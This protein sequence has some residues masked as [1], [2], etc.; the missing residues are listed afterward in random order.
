MA[1]LTGCES[2]AILGTCSLAI[3]A[4]HIG[5]DTQSL[6]DTVGNFVKLQLYTY[7]EVGSATLTSLCTPSARSSAETAGSAEASAEYV[8]EML[9]YILHRHRA[10]IETTATA[11]GEALRTHVMSELVVALTFFV[12]AEDVIGLGGLLEF[13]LSF[14]VAGILVGVIFDS[15]LAVGLLY[16]F[17]RRILC[18]TEHFIVIAFLIHTGF[19]F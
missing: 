8:A 4:S 3:G 15:K 17:G 10:L 18:H 12:V 6:C 5:R 9:E 13:L 16:L 1:S 7:T 19:S 11:S 2:H 14:F